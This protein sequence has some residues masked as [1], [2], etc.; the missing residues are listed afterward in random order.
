MDLAIPI[1]CPLVILGEFFFRNSRISLQFPNLKKI[2]FSYNVL[3]LP[4]YESK[5][6]LEDRLLKAINYSKG[7]GMV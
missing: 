3:L 2:L 7:F 5:E 1:D 6:K 4:E